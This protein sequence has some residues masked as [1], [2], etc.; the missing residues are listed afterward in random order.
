MGAYAHEGIVLVII[1]AGLI[2]AIAKA[3]IAWFRSR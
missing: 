2:W 1:I 3:L